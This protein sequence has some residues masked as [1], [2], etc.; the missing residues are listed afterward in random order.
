MRSL[1]RQVYLTLSDVIDDIPAKH[2]SVAVSMGADSLALFYIVYNLSKEYK[3]QL[4]AI[5]LNHGLRKESNIEQRAFIKLMEEL[6]VNFYT[7]NL[8][9]PDELTLDKGKSFELWARNERFKFYQNAKNKLM[10]DFLLTAHHKDDNVETFFLN[11]FR[12]TGL[13]GL[14]GIMVK[15]GF[16]VSPLLSVEKKELYEYLKESNV[17]FFED[18][19]NKDN[20]ARRNYIRNVIFPDIEKKFSNYKNSIVSCMEEVSFTIDFINSSIPFW[21]KEDE[22]DLHLFENLSPYLQRYIMYRKIND[23]LDF[24][25]ENINPKRQPSISKKI[26]NYALFKIRTLKNGEILQFR[27]IKIYKS[28]NR[29]Y[30]VI[31]S[32]SDSSVQRSFSF[33]KSEIENKK[34]LVLSFNQYF[35]NIK[36][37]TKI[38]NIDLNK[39]FIFEKDKIVD[40]LIFSKWEKGDFIY[41]KYG[42]KKLQDLFVDW[43]IPRHLRDK[44]LV[45][46]DCKNI[47]GIFIPFKFANRQNYILSDQY[48]IDFQSNYEYIIVSV[49]EKG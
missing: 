48:F 14:A 37:E 44:I 26:V 33:D 8:S 30:F 49:N 2:L 17:Q 36:I 11:L 24:E 3:F 7:D 22:W 18:Y 21:Y 43:K 19:T 10:F 39:N 28:Y 27:N 1:E 13:K 32:V 16:I 25:L 15:R 5:H 6:S 20:K 42:K 4:S 38:D 29:I 12:G 34:N 45:L 35:I 41:L 9:V 31:Y 40:R 46:K 47:I 23:L